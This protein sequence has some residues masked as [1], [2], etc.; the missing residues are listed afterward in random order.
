MTYPTNEKGWITGEGTIAAVRSE[1]DT[2][3]LSFSSGKD[4]I[5][6]WLALRDKIKVVPFYF[7]LVPDL[8]FIQESL[9]YYEKFFGTKIVRIPSPAL[10]DMIASGTY[11]PLHRRDVVENLG[12]LSY[13]RD[14]VRDWLAEDY[15]LRPSEWCAQGVRECDNLARRAAINM[16]KGGLNQRRRQFYPVWDWS[17]R[18]LE[19]ELLKSAVKLPIDYAMFGRSFDGLDFRYLGPI[20]K[21]F[22]K[23]FARILEWF[24]LAE[25][26]LHRQ[27]SIQ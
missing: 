18:R 6:T 24:P 23:D 22:P 20:K 15:G 7:Y 25:T 2:C 8:E 3:L 9:A 21:H 16:L 1:T 14:Q 5:G 19:D 12:L 4:A 10:Y 17:N 27:K 11:M 26:E 13:T